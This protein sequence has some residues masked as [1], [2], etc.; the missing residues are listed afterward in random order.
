MF[1][2]EDNALYQYIIATY[3]ESEKKLKDENSWL[4]GENSRLLKV[5][6]GHLAN[7]DGE[8]PKKKRKESSTLE[9]DLD[10]EGIQRRGSEEVE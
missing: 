4:K 10:E 7:S 3:E 5:A 9:T 2:L 1:D 6:Q 8:P